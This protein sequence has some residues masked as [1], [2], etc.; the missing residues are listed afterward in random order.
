[1]PDARPTEAKNVIVCIFGIK[2]P[3]CELRS[4]E[5]GIRSK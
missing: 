5:K 4:R 2:W 3:F 1:M